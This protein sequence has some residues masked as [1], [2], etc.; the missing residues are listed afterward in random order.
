MDLD[1]VR[2]L[3]WR[4]WPEAA[5][6]RPAAAPRSAGEGS[7]FCVWLPWR[8]AAPAAPVAPAAQEGRTM[9]GSTAPSTPEARAPG[10]PA[11]PRRAED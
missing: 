7:R 5:G 3:G 11:L 1:G 9:P 8:A 10:A 6:G 2:L 4:E